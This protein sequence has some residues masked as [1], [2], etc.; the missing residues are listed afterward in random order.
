MKSLVVTIICVSFAASN[1]K[2]A[3]KRVN[4]EGV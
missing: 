4:N 3:I 1:K 2:N